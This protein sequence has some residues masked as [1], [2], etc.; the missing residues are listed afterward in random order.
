MAQEEFVVR[1][2]S[3]PRA[4][5]GRRRRL[6]LTAALFA[7][8]AAPA[9]VFGC[10]FERQSPL[11]A[12]AEGTPRFEGDAFVT[13]DGARL[14]L[15]VWEPDGSLF[16]EPW[17]VLVAVHGM[18]EYADAFHLAG[19]YWASRGVKVYA[20]DQRGFGRSPGRGVWP[21]QELMAADVAAAVAAARA[22]N[23]DAVVGVVGESMGGAVVLY[24]ASR[25]EGALADRVILSAPGVRGWSALPW[26]YRVSLW[27][28]AHVAPRWAARPPR[29]IGV[30]ATDNIEALYRNG[31]DPLF[32]RDTRMD[33][34]YGLVSLM[35]AA[36]KSR[37]SGDAPV[38]MLYGA[39]DQ[40][41]PRRAVEAAAPNL[42]PCGRTA[43]YEEGWHMLFRDLQARTVW[44]DV[45][46]F[47]K[48]PDAPLP[49]AAP[50]ILEAQDARCESFV[51]LDS[52]AG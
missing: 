2:R 21:G 13:F 24:A 11:T 44:D 31:R 27:S 3:H 25:A 9:L 32:L 34:L 6:G 46:S 15:T 50:P 40:L 16:P 45:L 19:P 10:A 47:L 4:Q 51:A 33:T 37:P 23:P 49:S 18:S 7:L 17:A 8:I 52:P 26:T 22:E 43:L 28:A 1:D 29:G 35:E 30:T 38:L 12:V 14:G 20:Y 48:A 42:G 5:T 36:S 39:N 41:I